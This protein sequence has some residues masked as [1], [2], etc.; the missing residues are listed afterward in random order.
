MTTPNI[1]ELRKLVVDYRHAEFGEIRSTYTALDNALQAQAARIAELE[2]EVL[3][4]KI[5]NDRTADA[6]RDLSAQLTDAELH[7]KQVER[8]LDK[9]TT[10]LEAIAATKPVLVVEKEPDYWS[11]G[12]F[13]EGSKPHI[14]PTKVW[15]LPIGTQ[16]F[17]S[18]MPA[19]DVTELVDALERVLNCCDIAECG[20]VPNSPGALKNA[21]TALSKYKGAK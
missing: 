19:Q 18:P 1:E 11:G 6:A 20:T 3:S 4:W 16:L 8:G 7:T 14:K 10:Q 2:T 13:H 17:T 9:A 21:R 5:C 15:S 12:H